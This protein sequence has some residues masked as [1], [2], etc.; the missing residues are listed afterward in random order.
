M[1]PSS[2]MPIVEQAKFVIA[3]GGGFWAAFSAYTWV[4][5]ALTNTQEG[6]KGIQTELT[7]QTQAIVKA[8]DTNTSEVKE[9]RTDVGRL[10]QS[11]LTPPPRARSARA[12][13]RKK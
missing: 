1:T 10:L 2:F 4:K 5:T 6:V 3:V 11:M 13:R 12:A 7:N 9:L 8:T